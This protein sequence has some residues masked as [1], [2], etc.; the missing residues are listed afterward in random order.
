MTVVWTI[1]LGLLNAAILGVLVRRLSR[2]G[3]GLVRNAVLS[4]VFGMALWPITQEAYRLLHVTDV[5]DVLDNQWGL[6]GAMVYLLLFG[7]LVAIQVA[8]LL[9]LEIVW[10]GGTL[11]SVA[12]GATR[13]PGRYRRTRR[14][15]EIQ[16]ILVVHGL[17]SYVRPR[18]PRRI[19]VDLD[20]LAATLA[21]ALAACGVTFVKLGQFAATRADAVPPEF[22]REFS[23]LQA[24][25][26]PVPFSELEPELLKSWGK[27]VDEVFAS[28][29]RRPL[30][31]ASV[32]QVHTAVLHDGTPVVVKVQR[33]RIRGQ[34]QADSDIILTLAESLEARAVWARQVGVYKLAESFVKSLR[35]E[36]DYREEA[37]QTIAMR[38]VTA[39][40]GQEDIVIPRI[41]PELSG[42][43]VIVMDRVAG[44]PLSKAHTELATMPRRLRRGLAEDLFELIARQMLVDG[45]FHADL[46]GGNI[47][48]QPGGTMG[49]IDFGAV[50]RLE[51]GDRQD[52]MI[53]LVALQTQD[54]RAATSAVLDMLGNPAGAN[55][56]MLQRDIG[57]VMLRFA[58]AGRGN[59]SELFTQL[60]NFF[61]VHGFTMPT[62]IGSAFRAIST[63]EGSLKVLDPDLDLLDMVQARGDSLLAQAR[64]PADMVDRAKLYALTTGTQLLELPGRVSRAVAH[65]EDGELNVGPTGMDQSTL[66]RMMRLLGDSLVQTVIATALIIGGIML[67]AADIGP[68][69]SSELK[70]FTY[71]GSWLLLTGAILAERVVAPAMT[72]R[73]G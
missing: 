9:G 41:Y 70:I 67:M 3:T 55:A 35:T 27:P 21:R 1:A 36:L 42:P 7:W 8:V 49:L 61:V 39:A 71:F 69:L 30:A 32:A 2:V 40:S 66:G 59:Y 45:T 33:P 51:A 34:V 68:T 37:A 64:R 24:E 43:T 48:I 57:D 54:S 26:P 50:G 28:F 17:S 63:L 72:R 25:V 16:R 11:G 56:R 14:L 4:L 46:H 53:L 58:T 60:A 38:E 5:L 12:R 18:L 65:L 44:T 15:L 23:K 52:I 31:A 19:H 29:D 62:P 22:V 20:S 13:V 73:S 10:P 6:A 47:L